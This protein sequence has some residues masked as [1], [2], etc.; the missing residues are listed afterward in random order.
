MTSKTTDKNRNNYTNS[1]N[2]YQNQSRKQLGVCFFDCLPCQQHRK[3][4]SVLDL[5]RESV[6]KEQVTD[7]A[8][9]VTNALWKQAG[10]IV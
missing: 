10:H 5:L 2:R 4:I 7:I 3:R 1:L 6:G 9:Y 8:E